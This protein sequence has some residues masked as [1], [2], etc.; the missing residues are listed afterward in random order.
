MS[1]IGGGLE[2]LNTILNATQKKINKF[3]VLSLIVD[4]NL[5][6]NILHMPALKYRR[7]RKSYFFSF[8]YS[9]VKLIKLKLIY[10]NQFWSFQL[11]TYQRR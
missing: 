8:I 1:R 7:E 9:I 2:E 3:K 11:L 10:L 6:K 4:Y 5:Y